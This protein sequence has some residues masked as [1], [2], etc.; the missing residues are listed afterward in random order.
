MIKIFDKSVSDLD[1]QK[2]YNFC[3]L[4]KYSRGERDNPHNPP[5]GLVSDLNNEEIIKILTRNLKDINYKIY[6]SYINLFLP[7]EKPYYHK[8]E[9][10]INA[11]TLLY[12]VNSEALNIDDE[13]ETYFLDRGMI[14][15]FSPLPGRII[16]FSG[17]ILHKAVPFR[18]KDRYTIA[19]K[20][21]V[22]N[23]NN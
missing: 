1:I 13:G 7:Y 19:I 17:N 4:Q 12:Y 21:K 3:K 14:S 8:D 22:Q 16:F 2:I 6:R 15:G 10:D 5:T 23:G 11:R 9:T 18:S 20:M